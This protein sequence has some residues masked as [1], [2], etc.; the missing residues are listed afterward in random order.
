MKNLWDFFKL[1]HKNKRREKVL[2][3]LT[4]NSSGQIHMELPERAK[5]V[6]V[7]L[8]G[9]Q[10][11]IPCNSTQRDSVRWYTCNFH[12]HHCLIIQWSVSDTREIVWEVIF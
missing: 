2:G 3:K 4:V 5:E 12:K 1:G 11:C 7:S 10:Q 8:K 9:E 6:M